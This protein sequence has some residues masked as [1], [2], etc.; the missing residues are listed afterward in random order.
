MKNQFRK[1]AVA[2][3]MA[4]SFA[5]AA[6]SADAAQ[7]YSFDF[8]SLLS[9]SYQPGSTFASMSVASTDDLTFTFNLVTYDLNS[10]F[11]NGAFI[12]NAIFNT[13]SGNDPVSLSFISGTVSGVSL[14]TTAPNV[15]SVAFDFGAS[16]PTSGAGGGA[17]RLTANESASWSITFASAQSTLFADPAAALHVQGL[18]REEGGSAWYTPSAPVPEP[19]TYAMLLAGIGLVGAIARRRKIAR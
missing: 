13:A 10:L 14:S 4:L 8:G 15:G 1:A 18:T 5:G 19:E 17:A 12:S 16:L 3:A 7:N 11:T 9:G 6:S 2:A